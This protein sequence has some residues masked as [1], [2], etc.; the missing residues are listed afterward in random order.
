MMGASIGGTT[1]PGMVNLHS[2]AFQR[3]MAGLAERAGTSD[4]SFWTWRDVMYRF[5][6]QLTPDD[7]EAIATLAYVEMLEAGYTRVVE[8]PSIPVA[9][10]TA[11]GPARLL[12][13]HAWAL[14]AATPKMPT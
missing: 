14:R 7:V 8:F 3:G 6:D 4:D 2:H 5:L 1:L 12:T 11:N 9:Q 10:L 13:G